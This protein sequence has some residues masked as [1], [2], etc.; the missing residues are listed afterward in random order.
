MG[1][2]MGTSAFVCLLF[3]SLVYSSSVRLPQCDPANRDCSCADKSYKS[4]DPPAGNIEPSDADSRELCE[5][6]CTFQGSCNWYMFFPNKDQANCVLYTEGEETFEQYIASCERTMQPVRRADGTC[7]VG[8]TDP[9]SGECNSLICPQGCQ[10]CDEADESNVNVFNAESGFLY[11]CLC[12]YRALQSK[13]VCLLGQPSPRVQL[14]R[15]WGAKVSN[16]DREGGF[17][18]RPDPKLYQPGLQR[19]LPPQLICSFCQDTIMNTF[20][21]H[22]KHFKIEIIYKTI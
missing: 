7:T 4:C 18:Q 13:Y 11:R 1:V 14:L 10:A 16:G 21:E 15:N 9:T 22:L 20:K 6:L 2:D 19:G 8:Q 5:L 12:H 3:A 17:H